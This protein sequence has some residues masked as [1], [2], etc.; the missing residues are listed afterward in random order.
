MKKVAIIG[1]AGFIG[2]HATQK[3]LNRGYAV[4]VGTKDNTQDKKYAHLNALNNASNLQLEQIDISDIQSLRG[5]IQGANIVVHT[6]TPFQLAFN[7]PE[8]DIIRPTVAGTRNLLTACVESRELEKLV[9]IASIVVYNGTFPLVRE[10]RAPDYVY[11]EED[12]Q[13]TAP[14]HHPYMQAKCLA[15]I[16][17]DK[18]LESNP[19]PG[20]EIASLYPS[21]VFGQSLSERADSLSTGIQYLIKTW[22]APDPFM[23]M[24]FENDLVFTVVGVEDVAE[25]ICKTAEKTGLHGKKYILSSGSHPVSD[26]S[27][28]MNGKPVEAN[29]KLLFD[30]SRAVKDLGMDFVAIE[31]LYEVTV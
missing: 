14:D 1:G 28:I 30:N 18:F 24:V 8:A 4:K 25:A 23:E 26:L 11:T 31:D 21:A 19:D 17:M 20:F 15:D 9:I 22:T 12:E 13:H 29:G 27:K 2:S 6:G 3:L 7:D 16:E 10:D 5:F